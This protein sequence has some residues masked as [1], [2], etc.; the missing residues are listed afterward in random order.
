MWNPVRYVQS[1]D[2][3]LDSLCIIG[4]FGVC[5]PHALGYLYGANFTN[6][7]NLLS[8]FLGGACIITI[9]CKLVLNLCSLTCGYTCEQIW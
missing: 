8:L 7:D 6:V 2:T 5:P 9:C 1:K 4:Y 3:L